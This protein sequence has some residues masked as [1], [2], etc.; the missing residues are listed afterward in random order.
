MLLSLLYDDDGHFENVQKRKEINSLSS[1]KD[2]MPKVI[3]FLQYLGFPC[4]RALYF[5]ADLVK[6]GASS[7]W[8]FGPYSAVKWIISMISILYRDHREDTSHFTSKTIFLK[9]QSYIFILRIGNANTISNGIIPRRSFIWFEH[10]TPIVLYSLL[11]LFITSAIR[12][13]NHNAPLNVS[14]KSVERFVHLIFRVYA[15]I[16]YFFLGQ[17]EINREWP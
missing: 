4:V 12:S 1:A 6:Q 14:S 10:V 2:Q 17:S 8:S 16:Y 9:T 3:Y 13:A 7:W 5:S 15:N 11:F